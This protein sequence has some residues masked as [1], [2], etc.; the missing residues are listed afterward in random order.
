LCSGLANAALGLTLAARCPGLAT[1]YVSDAGSSYMATLLRV[2][3]AIPDPL[4]VYELV[5]VGWPWGDEG[6]T[7]R[8]ALES[9]I[10]QGCFEPVNRGSLH[11]SRNRPFLRRL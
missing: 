8:R 4:A 3:Y 6:S 1:R 2:R 11:L 9:M 5:P 10:R 7:P